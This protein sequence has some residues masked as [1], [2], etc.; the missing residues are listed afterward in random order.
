MTVK[1]AHGR[2]L[3]VIAAFKLLKALALIA[4]GVGA[5]RL[6]HKDVAAIAEHWINMFQVDPRNHFIDLL[7]TK[8]ANVDDH[9]LKELSIGTFVYAGI[10]LVEGVGLAL[11]KRWAEYFTIITTSSLLPIE[12][13]ELVRRVSVGRSLALAINLGVVAYLIFELRRFPKRGRTEKG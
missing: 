13:Y 3:R 9:R 6:L 11:K 7:L 5:L 4:V 12:I 10:F 2:G 1:T 8:L